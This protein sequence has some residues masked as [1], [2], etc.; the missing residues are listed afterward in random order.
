[1]KNWSAPCGRR[2]CGSPT[3]ETT[4][5]RTGA[6]VVH[7]EID[8]WKHRGLSYEPLDMHIVRHLAQRGWLPFG[9]DRHQT[10]TSS[11]AISAI[12]R[13]STSTA[14]NDTVPQPAIDEAGQSN[15]V[16]RRGIRSTLAATPAPVCAFPR[17]SPIRANPLTFLD[18][19][20]G[21]ELGG[22]ISEHAMLKS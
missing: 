1:M 8:Q 9:P 16:R 14:P 13:L 5:Y 21:S 22:H 3:S 6:A 18:H 10:S 20:R 2:S 12:A 19:R 15:R 7:D 17:R 11:G 4:E